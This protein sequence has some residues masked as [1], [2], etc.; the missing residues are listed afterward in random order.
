MMRYAKQAEMMPMENDYTSVYEEFF[1][2]MR[3]ITEYDEELED[4]IEVPGE[5]EVVSNFQ[6]HE[7]V[8]ISCPICCGRMVANLAEKGSNALLGD[9]TVNL[10]VTA[11]SCE[12]PKVY[13]RYDN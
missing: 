6:F 9:V 4:D 11:A 3:L 8:I 2:S 5:S 10:V 12:C 7:K 1:K 13:L